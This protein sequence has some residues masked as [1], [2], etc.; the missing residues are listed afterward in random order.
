MVHR[1]HISTEEEQI[2]PIGY[3]S[4][5]RG[6]GRVYMLL[7]VLKVVLMKDT[8]GMRTRVT[9][10]REICLLTNTFSN[11]SPLV[12]SVGTNISI[13]WFADHT[14]KSLK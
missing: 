10:T 7:L 13:V 12:G 11:F 4:G 14:N 5:W 6:R 9:L 8:C 3:A 1:S 2:T